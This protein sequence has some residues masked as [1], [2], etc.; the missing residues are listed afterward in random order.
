MRERE[1]EKKALFNPNLQHID[2]FHVHITPFRVH[3]PSKVL[4]PPVALKVTNNEV[5][6]GN[7]TFA[8]FPAAFF[9][10]ESVKVREC[11]GKI[12][13]S[14]PTFCGMNIKLLLPRTR[15][16]APAFLSAQY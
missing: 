2:G 4:S 11:R 14:F 16:P 12:N 3:T 10:F 1:R 15:R 7:T 8:G 9:V 13:A 6:P 5:L